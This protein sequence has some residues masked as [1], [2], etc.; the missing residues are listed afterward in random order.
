MRT[1][2]GFTP[3]F[4]LPVGLREGCPLSPLL[5]ALFIADAP[6]R[7]REIELGSSVRL[8]EYD[9]RSLFFADDAALVAATVPDLQRLV[10]R[11]TSYM[12]EK[13]IS[14]NPAKSEWIVLGANEGYR[15]VPMEGLPDSVE[16]N[17]C[18]GS[19]RWVPVPLT[20][21]G[22]PIRATGVF[23]YLGVRIAAEADMAAG[24]NG[25]GAAGLKAWSAFRSV[26]Y[27]EP[28]MPLRRLLSLHRSLVG[29]C[30]MYGAEAWGPFLPDVATPQCPVRSLQQ[31]ALALL[32][33]CRSNTNLNK[34]CF[35]FQQIPWIYH[36]HRKALRFLHNKLSSNNCELFQLCLRHLGGVQG[37]GSWLDRTLGLL[38]SVGLDASFDARALSLSG[39]PTNW[40]QTWQER[41]LCR[42]NT[43]VREG[44]SAAVPSAQGVVLD[45]LRTCNFRVHALLAAVPNFSFRQLVARLLSGTFGVARVHGHY[46]RT[47]IARAD[48]RFCLLCLRKGRRFLDDEAHVLLEC[49]VLMPKRLSILWDLREHIIMR[50]QVGDGWYYS[51]PRDTSMGP[52]RLLPLLN[53]ILYTS[54]GR[55]DVVNAYMIGLFLEKAWQMR[56]KG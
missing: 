25:A 3:P 43:G 31:A 34:L 52:A 37:S 13:W 33:G 15:V 56:A 48:R 30:A 7:L 36:I 19:A 38:R 24:I 27:T 22:T 14:I 29:S 2:R 17:L 28:S 54:S 11:F 55:V 16:C 49:P 42:V 45:H 41:A 26:F 18:P 40:L 53:A 20:C 44:W 12:R 9:L 6:R 4:S 35:L 8:A 1:E 23:K 47:D 5:F 50:E 46:K 39:V 51:P 21:E 10:D 32:G